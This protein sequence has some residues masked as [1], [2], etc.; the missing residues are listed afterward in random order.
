MCT[1]AK[2]ITNDIKIDTK[3]S[4]EPRFPLP[5]IPEGWDTKPKTLGFFNVHTHS[6]FDRDEASSS[7]QKSVRRGYLDEAIQWG[8]EQFW[9]G[10]K[11]VVTNVWNRLLIMTVEDIGPADPYA[12][13]YVNYCLNDKHNY[14]SLCRAI[15]YLTMTKKT[16]V[17]D[18]S[19]NTYLSLGYNK[20]EIPLK[21]DYPFNLQYDAFNS[22]IK[23]LKAKDVDQCIR[24]IVILLLR[25]DKKT[26]WSAFQSVVNDNYF[27]LLVNIAKPFA[28]GNK[29][30]YILF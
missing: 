4:N 2:M 28:T 16:R 11:A 3:S 7:L 6:Y 17:D 5:K 10:P 27:N 12:I 20:R 15:S 26:Y 13:F 1:R 24:M 23:A 29:N 22:V 30:E 8:L 18:W 19:V 9:A 25:R 21:S 14:L